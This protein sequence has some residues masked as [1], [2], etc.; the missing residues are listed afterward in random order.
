MDELVINQLDLLLAIFGGV[1]S[2]LRKF[3]F[4]SNEPMRLKTFGLRDNI[5]IVRGILTINQIL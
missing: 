4:N 2:L 1:L 3:K 5:I